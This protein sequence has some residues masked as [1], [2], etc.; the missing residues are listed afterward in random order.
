[1]IFLA[2]LLA[3]RTCA[4]AASG[5]YSSRRLLFLV[6][7]RPRPTLHATGG[8]R[9]RDQRSSTAT[10]ADSTSTRARARVAIPKSRA[11]ARA[12]ALVSFPP[13]RRA[14]R[15]HAWD[16]RLSDDLITVVRSA[17]YTG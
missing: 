4:R 9:A 17:I 11:R 6:M 3:F 1:M 7:F 12:R 2:A 10:P 16:D 14:R 8:T 5:A 13:A 15:P